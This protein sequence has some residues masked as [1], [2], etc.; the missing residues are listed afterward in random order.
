MAS[1]D[2]ERPSD[3]KRARL[4]TNKESLIQETTVSTA[5]SGAKPQPK[6]NANGDPSENDPET[7]LFPFHQFE[8]H[9]VLFTDP[10]N[11]SMCILGDFNDSHQQGIVV[12]EKQPLTESSIPHLFSSSSGVEKKFQNDVYS[13]YVIDCREGGVGEVRV[14]T[15]YPATEAHVRKYETQRC[16]LVQETPETYLNIT[17]PF[18]EKQS[19]SLNVRKKQHI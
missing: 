14:T 17:K 4:G 8:A 7:D 16:R 13:Q 9:R 11:K 18:A 6:G 1:L 10:R 3:A 5:N 19:L 15:V 12:V 2:T